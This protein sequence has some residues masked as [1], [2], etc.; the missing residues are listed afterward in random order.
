MKKSLIQTLLLHNF[1]KQ[2]FVGSFF[3]LKCHGKQWSIFWWITV[4][5]LRTRNGGSASGFI[6]CP[7]RRW[8]GVH[9]DSLAR[10]C[11]PQQAPGACSFLAEQR[12]ASRE[13]GNLVCLFLIINPMCSVH[14][15][16]QVVLF[17]TLP[18]QTPLNHRLECSRKKK[19]CILLIV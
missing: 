15:C 5:L 13:W 2:S 8:E 7:A 6:S 18:Y 17:L 12:W 10:V 3:L 1:P 4:T 14:H 9:T 16:H 11:Q 19:A